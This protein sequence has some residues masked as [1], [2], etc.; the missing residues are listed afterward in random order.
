MEKDAR[1]LWMACIKEGSYVGIT[2][3]SVTTKQMAKFFIITYLKSLKVIRSLWMQ[4][5]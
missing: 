3:V 2:H 5:D 4:Q 1:Y